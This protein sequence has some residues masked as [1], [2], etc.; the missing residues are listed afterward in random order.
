M[1][2]EDDNKD[3]RQSLVAPLPEPTD[4]WAC[5]MQQAE[6]VMWYS[7]NYSRMRVLKNK[8]GILELYQYVFARECFFLFQL[9]RLAACAGKGL[10]FLTGMRSMLQHK[11]DLKERSN[12]LVEL[13]INVLSRTS[14]VPGGKATEDS[15]EELKVFAQM[16]DLWMVASCV[17]VTRGC[18]EHLLAPAMAH[19][20]EPPS[21]IGASQQQLQRTITIDLGKSLSNSPMGLAAPRDDSASSLLSAARGRSEDDSSATR[22]KETAVTLCDLLHVAKKT[23]MG[24]MPCDALDTAFVA[25]RNIAL[26][27]ADA[28]G[29]WNSF[30]DVAGKFPHVLIPLHSLDPELAAR[31][32]EDAA[33]SGQAAADYSDSTSDGIVVEDRV[34][35]ERVDEVRV[36]SSCLASRSC[37]LL[38]NRP[39]SLFIRYY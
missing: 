3:D 8:V 1:K 33:P 6:H 15:K 18:W 25:H 31:A 29:G 10:Q 28:F 23:L 34:R 26:S 4:Q 16:A 24:C 27:I 13:K 39:Q 5:V 30:R 9:N 38:E 19:V 7:I 32:A 36:S 11:L 37:S 20:P 14:A 12:Q 21:P 22:I 35:Q 17:Q 2:L